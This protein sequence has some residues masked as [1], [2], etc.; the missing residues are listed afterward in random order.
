MMTD[1][2][3]ETLAPMLGQRISGFRRLTFVFD[4]EVVN[5]GALEIVVESGATYNLDSGSDGESLAISLDAWRDPFAEPLSD[6]NRLFI[7]ESGRWIARVIAAED[8]L[9]HLIG[10]RVLHLTPH[11]SPDGRVIGVALET[12][13]GY[14]NADVDS[15][16]LIVDA[17]VGHIP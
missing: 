2:S 13:S 4:D 10:A 7:A 1:P 14:L 11:L 9:G 6:E 3:I 5:E 17:S 15:D 8:V 16:E 12:S